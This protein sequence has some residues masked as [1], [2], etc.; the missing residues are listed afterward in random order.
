LLGPLEKS[1]LPASGLRAS[2]PQ[3]QQRT[4]AGHEL[5]GP[6]CS[7]RR[8][9]ALYLGQPAMPV[10]AASLLLLTTLAPGAFAAP[11]IVTGRKAFLDSG[12]AVKEADVRGVH[13][14]CQNACENDGDSYCVTACRTEM[15]ACLDSTLPPE[16]QERAACQKEVL[17]KYGKYEASGLLADGD[18][19]PV[20]VPQPSTTAATTTPFPCRER[21]AGKDSSSNCWTECD[22]AFSC[23]DLCADQ[24][25]PSTC[26]TECDTAKYA[27]IDS[28]LPTEMDKRAKCRENVKERFSNYG[29]KFGDNRYS[30]DG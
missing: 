26:R 14:E 7:L 22:T 23:K 2:T 17:K 6:P 11:R 8:G 15:Y 13:L 10:P 28:T 19:D 21:C 24:A 4:G 30:A 29:D 20:G 1:A 25:S 27:C 9:P 5:R 12:R 18:V 16:M 3:K